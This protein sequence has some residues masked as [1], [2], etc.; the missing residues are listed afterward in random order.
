MSYKVEIA[1][2]LSKIGLT[3]GTKNPDQKHNT[4]GLI[5]E[6]YLWD[7]VVRFAEA[8]KKAAWEAMTKEG[9]IPDKKK[10]DPG[11]HELTYSPSFT[12]IA[13]VTQPV[14]RFDDEEF[15]R[16]M[17]EVRKVPVSVTKELLDKA[18]MPGNSIVTMKVVE[19]GT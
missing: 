8:K 5:G 10:L 16:L 12:V 15:A 6:A 14:K 13:K 11:D 19:R 7:E 17:L 9:L 2:A 4:G 18:R 1:K 3:N